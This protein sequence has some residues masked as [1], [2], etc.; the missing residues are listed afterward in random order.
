[1][2]CKTQQ[3]WLLWLLKS[4]TS[5]SGLFC[6]DCSAFITWQKCTDSWNVLKVGLKCQQRNSLMWKA[7]EL[8]LLCMISQY[9]SIIII[10]WL[11][12]ITVSSS[13]PDD[14]VILWWYIMF[15]DRTAKVILRSSHTMLFCCCCCLGVT[16]FSQAVSNFLKLG[17]FVFGFEWWYH[18]HRSSLCN[19]K[20]NILLSLLRCCLWIYLSL[21]LQ[22]DISTV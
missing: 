18:N 20:W 12:I 3:L 17:E 14:T 11:Y 21:H 19:Y 15:L 7:H 2:W 6:Q 10:T 1:M 5:S 16:R 22:S 4:V 13:S 8:T 9:H